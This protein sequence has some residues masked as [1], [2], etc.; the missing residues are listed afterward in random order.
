MDG[1]DMQLWR[2]LH[3]WEFS[4]TSII[5]GIIILFMYMQLLH[6]MRCHGISPRRP[7]RQRSL[8]RCIFI[9]ILIILIL[10]VTETFINF[11][12]GQSMCCIHCQSWQM[13]CGFSTLELIRWKVNMCV[14]FFFWN[15]EM[16]DIDFNVGEG[17][18]QLLFVTIAMIMTASIITTCCWLYSVHCN[19]TMSIF[20][21][22]TFVHPCIEFTTYVSSTLAIFIRMQTR[23]TI[24]TKM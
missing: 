6:G 20:F 18:I 1:T 13:P 9:P 8:T 2:F 22:V 11:T 16:V 4:K 3:R 10:T 15:G 17:I 5:I 24:I 23:E 21:L 12:I 7:M 19:G 14:F